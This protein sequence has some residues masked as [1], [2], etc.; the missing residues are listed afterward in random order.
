MM[1]EIDI[2]VAGF[3]HLVDYLIHYIKMSSHEFTR[4][5]KRERGREKTY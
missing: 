2:W 4:E 3:E 1:V 5:R